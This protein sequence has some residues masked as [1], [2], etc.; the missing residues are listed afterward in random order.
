LVN[1][2]ANYLSSLYLYGSSTN[3]YAIDLVVGSFDDIEQLRCL[4]IWIQICRYCCAIGPIDN[5]IR[6]ASWSRF[7]RIGSVGFYEQ[8]TVV[9]DISAG[10]VNDSSVEQS[11]TKY[12]ST[13]EIPAV[14]GRPAKLV[15]CVV[16]YV[17][18]DVTS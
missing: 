10:L 16:V 2:G 8:T 17:A 4:S 11:W 1:N 3:R 18:V 5:G 6:V 7:D 15:P 12:R 13:I 14:I 9:E